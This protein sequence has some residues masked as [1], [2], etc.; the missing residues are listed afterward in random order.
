MCEV[1]GNAAVRFGMSLTRVSPWSGAAVRE[2]AVGSAPLA[3][4]DWE[5]KKYSKG[6]VAFGRDPRI[7]VGSLALGFP[8]TPHTI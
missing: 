8:H 6:S 5:R 3:V 7:D 4:P 2:T 1:G